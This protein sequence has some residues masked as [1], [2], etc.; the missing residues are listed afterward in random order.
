MSSE[1]RAELLIVAGRIRS[2]DVGIDTV[3][4]P[5]TTV[6]VRDG[7]IVSVG[8]EAALEHCVGPDTV[9]HRYPGATV[10]P[11][12]TDCHTHIIMGLPLSRGI[13]LTDR[14]LEEVRDEIARAAASGAAG[15]RWILGWGLDPNVFESS[16][17]TGRVFDD[18]AP[19]RPVFLRMRDAHS[20]IVNS[21][22]VR[23]LGLTGREEFE[24]ESRIDVDAAGNVTGY[25]VEIGAIEWLLARIPPESFDASVARVTTLLRSMAESGLT[26]NHVL[27][28]SEEGAG[29]I[30]AVEDRGGLPVRLRFSPMVF[31]GMTAA[32]LERIVELQGT[33]GRRWSVEGVKFF[34]DGTVDNGTAWLHEPDSAGQGTRSIWTDPDRYRATQRFFAERGIPT[35]THAIGDRG[36]DFVLDSLESLGEEIRGR[37]PHR[38]EHIE[39]IGDSTVR[40]FASLGVTASMQPIHGTHHTRAD[41]SDNWSVRLGP[42]R[43]SHG[44]RC[45]DIR[46]AGATVALGS[47]WPVTPFD[48]RSMIAD[49]ILRRPVERPETAPVQPEQALTPREAF[50]GYTVHAARSVRHEDRF[51][52]IVPGKRAEFTVFD[53]DPFE[54]APERYPDLTVVATYLDGERIVGA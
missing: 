46:D 42:A 37:A 39:T 40:R 6:A 25:I 17:F 48:P 9:I 32:E 4:E 44:W 13:Q 11:G 33:G 27:D 52:S 2:F 26:A 15:E 14:S 45:R 43:A 50:E 41:R 20:A 31:P 23:E 29:L 30:S 18:L 36:V 34:I 21:A 28:F 22:A 3:V 54:I 49:T 12:L 7:R 53:A 16:G 35:T 38:I 47:D 8:S 1:N 51:G 19:D 5:P 10:M 24:D